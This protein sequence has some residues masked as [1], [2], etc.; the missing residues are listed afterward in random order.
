MGKMMKFDKPG[1]DTPWKLALE[2]HFAIPETVDE[3][4]GYRFSMAGAFRQPPGLSKPA[5]RA[6]G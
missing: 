1:F 5:D 3:S 4:L 6:D 2:E